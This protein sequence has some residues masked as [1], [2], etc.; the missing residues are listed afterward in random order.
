MSKDDE[1][2]LCITALCVRHFHLFFWGLFS[3]LFVSD[4]Y[5][6]FL[7][8]LFFSFNN[9]EKI[10]KKWRMSSLAILEP[11][12]RWAS[13]KNNTNISWKNW[14]NLKIVWNFEYYNIENL[15]FD[16]WGQI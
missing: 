5:I 7:S 13:E 15:E 2:E 4:F 3:E 8:R 6:I 11:Q 1:T 16:N 14:E 9:G 12:R 10:C